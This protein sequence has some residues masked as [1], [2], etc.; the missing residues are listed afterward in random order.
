VIGDAKEPG[1][2]YHAISDGAWIARQI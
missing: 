1:L 2:T